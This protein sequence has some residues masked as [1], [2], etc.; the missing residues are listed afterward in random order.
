MRSLSRQAAGAVVA[1]ATATATASVAAGIFLNPVWIG[2]E[3]DR[4]DVAGLTGYTPQEVRDVT[5]SILSDLVFGP[6]DFG[7]A[8]NGSPVLDTRER[9]HMA[10]VRNV[11]AALGL[12]AAAAWLVVIAG[13]VVSRLSPGF[14]RAVRAGSLAL[15]VGVIVVGAAFGLF[16]DQAFELMH[17][18][19]FP[20]G[21]YTFDPRTERLVQLFPTQF[22]MET[23]VALAL[24]A[25]ALALG[26]AFASGRLARR[27]SPPSTLPP[28]TEAES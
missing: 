27:G 9:G 3:Q 17:E 7:V 5:G 22:W 28:E 10:D 13:A 19:F 25:L 20:A 8:V 4:S 23:S 1:L 16:F 15:A 11:F 2:F 21:T 12:A 14:W 6:P 26:L 24:A 18:T